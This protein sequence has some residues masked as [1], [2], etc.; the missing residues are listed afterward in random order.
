MYI[1]FIYVTLPTNADFGRAL[2]AK[3]EEKGLSL[4]ALARELGV[5]PSY[6]SKAELGEVSLSE[7]CLDRAAEILGFDPDALFLHAGKLTSRMREIVSRH[8]QAFADLIKH[9]KTAPEHAILRVVREVRD[10]EW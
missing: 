10:G 1:I 7:D 8:P 5:Q 3:R 4:R 6:L 9:L 2:R